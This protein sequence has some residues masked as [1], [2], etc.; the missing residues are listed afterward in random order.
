VTTF[1]CE[2]CHHTEFRARANVERGLW[3]T[4]GARIRAESSASHPYRGDDGV[5][6]GEDDDGEDD[7]D[8]VD[9]VN[10]VAADAGEATDEVWTERRTCSD[11]A[12][13]G[14]LDADGRCKVCGRS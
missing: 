2:G 3:W 1:V 12:C 11:G 4:E 5:G 14:L 6:D 13:I 9:D 8:D 7:E 10:E